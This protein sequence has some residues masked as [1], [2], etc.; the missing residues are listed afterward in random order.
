MNDQFLHKRFIF[1]E[2]IDGNF[3]KSL[4]DDDFIYV[5]E[6]FKTTLD[7]L[8]PLMGDIPAAYNNKDIATLKRIIHKIKPAFGFT[9]FLATENACKA[10]EDA[11]VDSL[12]ANDLALLYVPLWKLISESRNTMQQQY[13]QLKEFNTQW[14]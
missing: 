6:I 12:T 7:Q 2:K 9:G 14:Y 1:N 8:N 5:E 11:C 4:Y 13:E 3:L 10:F